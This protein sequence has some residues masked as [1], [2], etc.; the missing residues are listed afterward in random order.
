MV[1]GAPIAGNR[2]ASAIFDHIISTATESIE[3]E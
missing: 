1:A 2:P 3:M